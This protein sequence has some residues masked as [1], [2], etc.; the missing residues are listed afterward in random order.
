MKLSKTIE[1]LNLVIL[2]VLAF[3][4]P[5]FFLPSTTEFFDTGKMALVVTG[6]LTLLILWGLRL[7]TE[8]RL[9]LVRTPLDILLLV[10]LLIVFLS[11]MLSSNPAISLYGLLP[12]I[13]GSLLSQVSL[14]LLYFLVV[15]NIKKASSVD[16]LIKLIISS[17]IVLSLVSLAAYFKIFLPFDFAKT[18][19]F[20]LAGTS[21]ATSLFLTIILPL[22][23]I[24]FLHSARNLSLISIFYFLALLLSLVTITLVGTTSIWV[25]AII[26][27]LATLYIYLKNNDKKLIFR[28]I[29]TPAMIFIVIVVS[30]LAI[31]S[32][33]P[34]IKDKT[35]FGK[36]SSDFQKELQLPFSTAWKISAS[37]F[38]DSPILG[39][40]PTTY[41]YNFTVYKPLEFNRTELWNT[42]FNASFSQI[43]QSWA[44]I[45]GAGVIFLL[46]I[47][48][49]FTFLALRYK[50][51]WG[52]GMAGITFILGLFL[53]PMT[54]LTQTT[55]I[56]ILAL[57]MVTLKGNDSAGQIIKQR[58]VELPPALLL[59]VLLF[60]PIVGLVALG[61]FVSGK[62]LVADIYHRQ[63]I[64][65]LSKNS[66]LDA[67]NKLVAAE[68]INENMD[69]YRIDLAQTNFALANSIATQKGPTE[70]SPSG[71]LTEQ[72]RTNI[73]QLLQQSI[74]EG[75]AATALSPKSSLN[76]EILGSIY[77]QI[78]G[79]ATNGLQYSLDAYGHAIA[80]DPY[81]PTLRLTVG[82]IY[83][84]AKNYD[85]AVRFF[86]DAV[87]LKPDYANGLYNLSIALRD[88]GNMPE[89]IKIA[90]TLVSQLQDKPES[91]DYK[92]A[93]KLLSELKSSS[94]E[95]ASEQSNVA[96]VQ[97]E[98]S[99]SGALQNQNLPKVLD[100]DLGQPG[101]ISTPAA[102]KRNE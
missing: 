17:S 4:L 93:S 31:L 39:T 48:F 8:E 95:T 63:A 73:Q 65:A 19:N 44:E 51:S 6:V 36:L 92:T 38:R 96:G 11:T 60:M 77:R 86:D 14:V 22:M 47:C 98:A 30:T 90:E 87:A 26:S 91:D 37:S 97:T 59:R 89:A 5:L 79:V 3:L 55:G 21:M 10:Y 9:V 28:G 94:N 85:L 23:I 58:S 72:D 84:Q 101:K 7:I 100:E 42:R 76:W 35:S 81:N 54:F 80:L 53:L 56:F 45:G 46:L 18:T 57:F 50:D 82:G 34:T 29:F 43:L 49:T 61:G 78:S 27:I 62:F 88:K 67:Y 16:L 2:C 1:S 33:T 40:G 66:G 69:L 20:S 41:L 12:R 32:Y 102:V 75:K 13:S 15:A 74:A 64:V 24:N 71:S 83:Y 52:L 68:R 25:L 70:A 99:N